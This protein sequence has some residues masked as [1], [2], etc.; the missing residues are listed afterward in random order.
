MASTRSGRLRLEEDGRG[1]RARADVVRTDVS[2]RIKALVDAGDIG[3][4]SIGMLVGKGNAQI[5]RSAD[6]RPHLVAGLPGAR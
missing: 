4:M 6:G 1:L 5:T 2:E 3:G